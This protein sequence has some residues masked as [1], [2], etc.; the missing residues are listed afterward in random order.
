MTEKQ[1]E[2]Q[3]ERETETFI[4]EALDLTHD[5]LAVTRLEDGYTVFVEDLLKGETAEI[6][7]VHRRK[8]FG[9]G[10]VISRLNRSPYRQAPKC[11]HFYECGGCQLMHMDY[12]VQ[13]AFK[14][15]RLELMLRKIDVEDVEVDDIISMVNPYYYRN[16]VDVKFTNGEEGIEAGFYKTKSHDLVHMEE[17]FIMPKKSFQLLTL[18]KNLLNQ[19]EIKAYDE[20]T[21][22]GLIKSVVLRESSKHKEILML[23]NLSESKLPNER[24]FIKRLAEQQNELVGVGITKTDEDA[25]YLNKPIRL[26]YGKRFIYDTILDIKYRIGFKSFFQVNPVQTERLYSKAI[27]MADLA[28]ADK[29]IDAYS[30]IG[31]IALN[32]AEKVH[33]VFGI[34]Q[35]RPAV[36]DAKR[37]AKLNKIRNAFFEVGDADKVL[38]KWKKYKFDAIFFDPPRKG[39]KKHFLKTVS[40]MKI[41][42]I[43]YISCNPA[44]LGRDL[45]YLIKH[46]YQIKQVAPVDM[47]PQTA[48]VESVTLL[49]LKDE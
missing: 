25:Y 7:V 6:E 8:N 16:K 28:P 19:Y 29:V 10:R 34:E 3:I 38:N 40:E 37:N 4:V 22:S 13:I 14:K 47:F 48:H 43:I 49:T 2:N 35:L 44:T 41:P 42:K 27:E 33:K 9:F 21:K 18:L 24:K 31:S 17:C 45:E 36:H 15:Y 26:V 23:L 32:I 1:R 46:G 30:G 20:K 12:D 11:K 39:C 5:G